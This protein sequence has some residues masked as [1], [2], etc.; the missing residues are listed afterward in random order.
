MW[1]DKFANW[2]SA[3]NLAG[4]GLGSLLVIVFFVAIWRKAWGIRKKPD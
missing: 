1:F 2:V 4:I 3:H